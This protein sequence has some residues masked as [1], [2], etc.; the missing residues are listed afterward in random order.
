MT[1]YSIEFVKALF[2]VII[3][4]WSSPITGFILECFILPAIT[5]NTLR[6]FT[7]AYNLRLCSNMCNLS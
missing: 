3:M 7:T 6:K 1:P 4:M 5:I 2:N